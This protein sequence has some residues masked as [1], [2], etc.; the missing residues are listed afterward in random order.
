MT[1]LISKFHKLIQS[2]IIWGGFA[3][4]ISVAFVIV[5]SPGS[6]N[7]N[8]GPQRK[9]NDVVGKL[10]G[11]EVTRAEFVTAY[12]NTDLEYLF[13]TGKFLPN[14]PIIEKMLEQS[15]WRRIAIL[16]KAE[17][18]K[19]T[20]TVPQIRQ[21]IESNPFFVD[22]RTRRFSKQMYD[23]VI[24][25]LQN[26]KNISEKEV[27]NFFKEQVLIG[28]ISS[29]ISSGALATK[30]EIQTAFHIFFDK[31]TVEYIVF[32]R[33]I[34]QSPKLPE[35][36]IQAYFNA[37][38]EQF[39][40]PEK[41]IVDYVEINVE[42]YTNNIT[43]PQQKIAEFYAQNKTHF[44]KTSATNAPPSAP[45]KYK[46]LSEAKGEIV[47]FLTLES[48]FRKAR[49]VADEIVAA[50]A[51]ESVRPETVVKKFGLKIKTTPKPFAKDALV[52]GIDPSA[53]FAQ[54]AFALLPNASEYYSDLVLGKKT[55]YVLFF[56]KRFPSYIPTF[57]QVHDQVAEKATLVAKEKAYA[58]KVYA[59]YDQIKIDLKKGISFADAIKKY[60]FELKT[61]VPF[62]L[63]TPLEESFG[64]TLKG[65]TIWLEQGALTDLLSTGDDFFVAYV[66]K[67]EVANEAKDLPAQRK[68]LVDG[69]VAQKTN[70]L[71]EAWRENI[72]TEAGFEDLSHSK[73]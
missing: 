21:F 42:N 5:Y 3:V 18:L 28:K 64:N 27:E 47:K 67:K 24:A 23:N 45:I 63:Q 70:R 60:R 72:L 15:A 40:I 50:L 29:V 43:I 10:Y 16:K 53:S 30:D 49:D 38:K 17:K 58:E 61:T 57:N 65:A 36:K 2:K 26:R 31:L 59:I 22:R 8:R 69:I 4:L 6:R 62:D 12:R 1:M 54:A 55:V 68:R 37:H 33:T 52:D 13:S 35:A 32:P 44:R 71:L 56:K 66:A 46:S 73:K 41:R 48:A 34:V 19:L 20:A 7:R 51:D 9:T 11:E 25:F 14:N 39:R